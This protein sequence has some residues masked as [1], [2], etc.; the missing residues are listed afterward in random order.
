MGDAGRTRYSGHRRGGW[1]SR[2]PRPRSARVRPKQA[3]VLWLLVLACGLTAL[4]NP[5]GLRLPMTWLEIMR[6]PVVARI[7]EE[8]A[9]PG[10]RSIDF[11]LILTLGSAYGMAFLSTLPRWPRFTWLIPF[12]WFALSLG[13]VRHAPQ[14]IA[15]VSPG[16]NARTPAWRHGSPGLAGTCS[17]P[18]RRPVGGRR[19]WKPAVIPLVIVVSAIV[20]QA[21]DVRAPIVGR[22]W[23]TLDPAVWPVDLLPELRRCERE[24]P[25]G[26][27]VFNDYVLGGFLIYFTPGLKVFVDDRCEV[28]GDAWLE[29]FAHAMQDDPRQM[30]D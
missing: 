11:W 3:I 18:D 23:A 17:V 28:Y 8:H 2:G 6:S 4:A 1:C 16:G 29:Q 22:G 25:S 14:A 30:D 12:L 26:A 10:P 13:R 9:P 19:D 27:R 20:L 15:V 24:H 21:A 5:Y 7:V